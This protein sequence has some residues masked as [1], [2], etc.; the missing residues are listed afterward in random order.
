MPPENIKKIHRLQKMVTQ[1]TAPNVAPSKISHKNEVI[2]H[3]ESTSDPKI[4][5]LSGGEL[6]KK[7]NKELSDHGLGSLNMM[8]AG[9]G[10][11]LKIR[12]LEKLLAVSTDVDRIHYRP[13]YDTDWNYLPKKLKAECM[14]WM[15]FRTRLRL[16]QTSKTEKQLVDSYPINF[17][18]VKLDQNARYCYEKCIELSFKD[19]VNQETY[20]KYK[21]PSDFME[22]GAPLLVYILKHGKIDEF[23][24]EISDDLSCMT[25]KLLERKNIKFCISKFSHIDINNFKETLFLLANCDETLEEIVFDPENGEE[26]DFE[27]LFMLPAFNEA[28]LVRMWTLKHPWVAMT[29]LQR[30]IHTDAKIG[31]EFEFNADKMTIVDLVIKYFGD[32]I[33][34]QNGDFLMKIQMNVA[35]RAILIDHEYTDSFCEV[36]FYFT[37]VSADSLRR[38]ERVRA[39]SSSSDDLVPDFQRIFKESDDDEIYKPD[40]ANVSNRN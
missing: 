30:Y 27:R 40:V 7:I 37:V 2:S 12:I 19:N 9:V 4:S 22:N 35:D 25:L 36:T 18:F 14:K 21:D 20:L 29:I 17:K 16:R 34:Y 15:S 28:K 8:N 24:Y 38:V 13:N 23:D 10:G 31:T 6:K 5:K 11:D 32:R 39:D 33:V 26:E 1:A 3:D